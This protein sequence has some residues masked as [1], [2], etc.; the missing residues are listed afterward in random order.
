MIEKEMH[1]NLFLK[2]KKKERKD[3]HSLT[4]DAI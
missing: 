2:K 4:I 3:S 1:A